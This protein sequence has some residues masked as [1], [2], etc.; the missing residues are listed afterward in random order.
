MFWIVEMRNGGKPV[1]SVHRVRRK[2]WASYPVRGGVYDPEFSL[3]PSKH[4]YIEI[5]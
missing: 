1:E 3:A 5:N 4:L 2:R